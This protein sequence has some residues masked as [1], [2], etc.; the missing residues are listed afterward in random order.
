MFHRSLIVQNPLYRLTATKNL[1]D[2]FEWIRVITKLP[3]SEQSYKGKAKT[4][5]YIN[6]QNQSTIGKLWKR[7]D[8]DLVKAFLKK[9][10]AESDF[11]APNLPLSLRLKGLDTCHTLVEQLQGFWEHRLISLEKQVLLLS[12]MSQAKCLYKL[13]RTTLPFVNTQYLKLF[14][15]L[16]VL[17]AKNS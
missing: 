17:F 9:W 15:I 5:K 13:L 4:H 8:P 2:V 16:L 12:N 10:W 14:D 1:E 6:R 7:N 11:K 3:N